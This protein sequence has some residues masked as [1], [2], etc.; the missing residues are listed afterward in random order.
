[1]DA[2]D[3]AGCIAGNPPRPYTFAQAEQLCAEA[4]LEM[5]EQNCAGAGCGY[6]THPVWTRLPCSA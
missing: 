3:E 5:C 4:G 1:M 6:N 2:N